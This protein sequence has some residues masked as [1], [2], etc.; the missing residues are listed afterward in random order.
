MSE[1]S[2]MTMI[3]DKYE[4]ETLSHH[5]HQS[6]SV[7]EAMTGIFHLFHINYQEE[8]KGYSLTQVK[9]IDVYSRRIFPIL[10]FIFV[11]YFFIRYKSYISYKSSVIMLSNARYHAIEGALSYT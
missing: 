6:I 4:E 3:S 8:P 9:K 1:D 5:I 2:T 10:F 7:T 11:F